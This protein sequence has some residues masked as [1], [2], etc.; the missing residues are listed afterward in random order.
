M[1]D[2]PACYAQLVEQHRPNFVIHTASPFFEEISTPQNTND[3]TDAVSAKINA[4]VRAS[5]LVT[6]A[7][8]GF[9]AQ[10]VVVTGAAT[11]VI[12]HTPTEDVYDDALKWASEKLQTRPNERA[13]MIAE[14]AMWNE[15][16][17][18]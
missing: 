16:L 2:N 13:K 7:A 8:C 9:E 5:R 3:K 4:Y 12:G 15:V 17:S 11:S 6:N 18:Y 10:Q 1:I 14:R